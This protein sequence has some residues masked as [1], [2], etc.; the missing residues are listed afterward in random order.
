MK[1]GDETVKLNM[2]PKMTMFDRRIILPLNS[3]LHVE[4]RGYSEND[5]F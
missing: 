4:F 1:I 5:N 3:M 2:E